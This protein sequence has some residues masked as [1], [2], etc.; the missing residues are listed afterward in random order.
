MTMAD[1]FYITASFAIWVTI[2]SGVIIVYK[3]NRLFTL[4]ELKAKSI[5]DMLKLS[6]LT[7]LSK[8]LESTKGGESNVKQK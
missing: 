3:L 1:F 7:L 5:K 6:G 2:I 4:A 8:I